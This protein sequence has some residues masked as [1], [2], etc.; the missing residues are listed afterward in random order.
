MEEEAR[1][2][3][4]RQLMELRDRADAK[5]L[6]G[7]RHLYAAERARDAAEKV[8]ARTRPGLEACCCP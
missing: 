4:A 1:Q 5:L 3:V 6:A 8:G 7:R 2:D